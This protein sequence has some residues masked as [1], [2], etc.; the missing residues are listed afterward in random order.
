MISGERL[1]AMDRG[2]TSDPFVE[3]VVGGKKQKTTT[4]TPPP[5]PLPRTKWTRRVPYPVLIGHAA[6]L[7]TVKNRNHKPSHRINPRNPLTLNPLFPPYTPEPRPPPR[8]RRASRHPGTSHLSSKSQPA[9]RPSSASS[10][11]SPS[12][13]ATSSWAPSP[14]AST[15]SRLARTLC[16]SASHFLDRNR[17]L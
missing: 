14:S 10:P 16:R 15:R 3:L 8:S 7:T 13:R 6:S 5:P 12:R 17:L 4:V 1:L 2:G 11:T 9:L